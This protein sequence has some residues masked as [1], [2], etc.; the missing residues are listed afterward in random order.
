MPISSS[1]STVR[2]R[3]WLPGR[4]RAA[5]RSSCRGRWGAARG[6]RRGPRSRSTRPR[7]RRRTCSPGR[8]RRSRTRRSCWRGQPSNGLPSML[9]MSQKTRATPSPLVPRQELEG[10]RG[11]GRART[12]A[13]WTRLKPSI[14]LPSKVI[15]WSRASSSS[16]GVTWKALWRP[17]TSVN[18]SWTKRTPRSSTVRRTYSA[19]RLTWVTILAPPRRR[20]RGPSGA[21]SSWRRRASRAGRLLRRRPSWRDLLRRD[22]LRAP[23][24]PGA[25]RRRRPSRPSGARRRRGPCWRWGGGPRG[26][27]R[28]SRATCAGDAHRRAAVDDAVGEL[29]DQG[30]VSW[31]PVRR[32]SMP[33]AVVG[34]VLRHAWCPSASQPAMIAS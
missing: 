1:T 14:A 3:S 32:S 21:A 31:A 11:P 29:V 5:G 33:D 2:R 7:G 24:A 4:R 23:R 17:R 19:W 10:R 20:R 25:P 15:P 9:V 12:S 13:S 26:S 16:A 34:D 27:P 8:A 18:H 6:R 22:L 30:A 28:L